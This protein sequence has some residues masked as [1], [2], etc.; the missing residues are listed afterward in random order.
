MTKEFQT[1]AMAAN[2]TTCN[3]FEILKEAGIPIA[4]KD[5]ISDTEFLSEKCIMIPLEV[6]A[7]R[8]AFGSFLE[9]EPNYEEKF[10]FDELLIEFF[11]K[12]TNGTCVFDEKIMALA[13]P[14]ED[15]YIA[16]M[17]TKTWNVLHP[18]LPYNDYNSFIESFE[19]VRMMDGRFKIEEVNSI[20][21]RVFHVLEYVWSKLDLKLVDFKIEFGLT[22]DGRLVVADV[23]DNDSW[24][25]KTKTWEDLSKQSFRDGEDLSEVERKYLRVMELS[26]KFVLAWYTLLYKGSTYILPFIICLKFI[27]SQDNIKK[28]CN[29]KITLYTF[30][31]RKNKK[32]RITQ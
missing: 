11:M 3:V 30:A 24:R 15:P 20:T 28:T 13:L 2:I 6:I 19:S 7:R 26:K 14:V 23:I 22:T 16:N 12:T 9:R 21:D 10:R 29:K 17:D 18:K 32:F 31:C 27:K 4:Y 5:K 8:Y 25:L 1:K